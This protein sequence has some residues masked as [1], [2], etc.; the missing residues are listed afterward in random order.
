MPGQVT[1]SEASSSQRGSQRGTDDIYD[2][3]GGIHGRGLHS[4]TFRLNVS[5]FCGLGATFTG[6][7]GGVYE[8]PG[9]VE[10]VCLCQKRLKLS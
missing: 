5:A 4:S 3:E 2:R 6:Y 7:S 1:S 8:V 10:G 9:G